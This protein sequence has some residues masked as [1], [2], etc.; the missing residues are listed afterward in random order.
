MNE[1][2]LLGLL[3]IDVFAPENCLLGKHANRP[4]QPLR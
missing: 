4:G 2:V 1:Y 3:D